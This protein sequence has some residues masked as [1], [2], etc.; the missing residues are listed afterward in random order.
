MTNTITKCRACGEEIREGQLILEPDFTFETG[1]HSPDDCI[2][3]DEDENRKF[4][5]DIEFEEALEILK[6]QD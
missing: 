1:L 5:R 6:Q 4:D 2:L 3:T